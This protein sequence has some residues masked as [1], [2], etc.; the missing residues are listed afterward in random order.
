MRWVCC[1][2][3]LVELGCTLQGG[4]VE[5]DRLR[6]D[7]AE[8]AVAAFVAVPPGGAF[9]GRPLAF[10]AGGI[11]SAAPEAG[12][13]GTWQW[14]VRYPRADI[15]LLPL[16]ARDRAAGVTF[17]ADVVVLFEQRYCSWPATADQ[18]VRC[19]PWQEASCC[20]LVWKWTPRGWRA[21]AP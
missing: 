15:L 4:S 20:N 9:P 7:L 5:T 16:T 17:A 14:Q 21:E 2:A 8:T 12:P 13:E 6:A 10:Q 18:G 11:Y 19:E 3:A 1:F